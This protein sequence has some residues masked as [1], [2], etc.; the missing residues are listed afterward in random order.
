[1][2]RINKMNPQNRLT[3][4]RCFQGSLDKVKRIAEVLEERDRA[5]YSNQHIIERAM[6]ALWEKMDM[7]TVEAK[8]VPA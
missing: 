6:D 3:S 1:M 7:D 8:G 2:Q 4:V 5:R